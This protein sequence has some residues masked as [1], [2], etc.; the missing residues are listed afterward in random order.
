M[1]NEFFCNKVSITLIKHR[2]FK[3]EHCHQCRFSKRNYIKKLT[4]H[5]NSIKIHKRIGYN[6]YIIHTINLLIIVKEFDLSHYIM[7]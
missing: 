2:R 4:G 5:Y 6:V 1:E 3:T 7:Y